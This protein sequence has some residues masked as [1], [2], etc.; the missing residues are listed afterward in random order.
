[1]NENTNGLPSCGLQT[2]CSIVVERD[3]LENEKKELTKQNT[4]LKTE[5]QG[6][7]AA[8]FD[9]MDSADKVKIL[10]R[11]KVSSDIKA[12]DNE[13]SL[14]KEQKTREYEMR[15]QAESDMKSSRARLAELGDKYEMDIEWQKKKAEV[16]QITKELKEV[17]KLLESETQNLSDIKSTLRQDTLDIKHAREVYED[18][19]KKVVNLNRQIRKLEK[20]KKILSNNKSKLSMRKF[21]LCLAGLCFI[22]S[23]CAWFSTHIIELTSTFAVLGVVNVIFYFFIKKKHN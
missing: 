8:R 6:L 2:E 15:V 20:K 10:E 11:I 13:I 7:E 21:N 17:R 18:L 19:R 23:I 12:R 14:L 4:D 3:K 16:I 1:M 9:D 5:I 22:S